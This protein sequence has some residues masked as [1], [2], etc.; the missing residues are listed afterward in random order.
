MKEYSNDLLLWELI[1]MEYT[2]LIR[3][4]DYDSWSRA[5]SLCFKSAED[6]HVPDCRLI[7]NSMIKYKFFGHF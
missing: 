6:N 5:Y 4:F 1:K 2:E 7:T 3:S